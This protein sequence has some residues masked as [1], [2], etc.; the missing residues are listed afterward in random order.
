MGEDRNR[1]QA[2]QLVDALF[3]GGHHAFDEEGLFSFSRKLLGAI[4]EELAARY[5]E[6]RGYILV[7]RNYRCS[8]GEADIVVYDDT[9]DEVVLVEVKTRRYRTGQEES[10]YP[11][12]SVTQRKQRRYRRIAY[13]YITDHYPV[14]AIRFDVIAVTLRP[15]SGQ[16]AHMTSAFDWEADL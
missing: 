9:T 15:G 4:G 7:E 11:E 10:T 13:C 1:A 12:E 8:E 5:L 14:P 2:R 16:V 3:N 6:Q